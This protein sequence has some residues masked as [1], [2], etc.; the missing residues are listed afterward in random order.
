MYKL[1]GDRLIRKVMESKYIIFQKNWKQGMALSENKAYLA[2]FFSVDLALFF[3]FL[4]F[5]VQMLYAF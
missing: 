5:T 1:K 3:I 4:H 2:I